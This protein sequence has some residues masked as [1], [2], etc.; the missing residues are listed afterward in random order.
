MAVI[1]SPAASLPRRAKLFYGVGDIG[2]A[3][4][5]SAVQFFLVIFYTD[6][7]LL[8]PALVGTA[9]LVAKAWDA[10]NDPLFGWLSDRMKATSLGKRRVFM[11][12]GAIP[13]GFSVA[14]LWR[15]PAAAAAT[16]PSHSS[17]SSVRSSCSTRSGLRP[18]CR[19]TR[20]PAN[21]PTTTTSAAR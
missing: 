10:I 11:I 6:A 7:A 18:T 21:L 17:G 8:S 20:L 2:N 4:V 3:L 14:L 16:R 5:N 12:L 13:L 9:L 15:V 19:T 1:A